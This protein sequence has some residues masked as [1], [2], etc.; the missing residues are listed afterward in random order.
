MV[1]RANRTI[2]NMIASYISDKQ[3][4]WDEHKPLLMLAYRSSIHE[5]LGVSPAMMMFGR[6]LTLPIDLA[7]GRP[8]KDERVC[9]TDHTYQLEQR[10]IEI[11]EFARKHLSIAS[12]SMKRK[13]DLKTN[14]N[15]Y[16]AGDPVWCFKPKRRVGFNPKLQA[17]WKGPMVVIERL[18]TVLYKLKSSPRAKPEIVHH[19]HMYPYLCDDKPTWFVDDEYSK[20]DN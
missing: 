15:V 16:K 6:D 17:H 3:D 10:L 12:D 20:G 5:T 18:N 13:Y 9:A 19:D 14:H 8:V 11:H 2:Q 7:L 4:D 1:E